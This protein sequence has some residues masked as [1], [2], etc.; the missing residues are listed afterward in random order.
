MGEVF[1][2]LSFPFCLVNM[3]F[4]YVSTFLAAFSC[5]SFADPSV[6]HRCKAREPCWPSISEW[7]TFNSS[8]SGRLVTTY[9]SAAVCHSAHYDANLCAIAK[10]N[11]TDSFWRTSQ[12]GAYAGI[13]WELGEDQCFIN[14]TID[15]PCDQ[16]RVAQFSVEAH[17]PADIQAAVRFAGKHDL[18]LVVKNTG[19]DHLGRSSGDGA[20]SIWTHNMKGREWHDNFVPNGAPSGTPGLP[21]VTLQA[22]E[23]WLGGRD[24]KT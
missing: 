7:S 1:L 13:L 6:R 20:F 2:L 9:P 15:A 3:F 22:G 18:Y 4:S 17:G 11:W 12:P 24:T 19:H 23:Q 16:G 21:A 8:I 14:T 10:E 5:S